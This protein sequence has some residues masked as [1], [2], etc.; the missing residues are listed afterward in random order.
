MCCWAPTVLV[1]Q[2]QNHTFVTYD[3]FHEYTVIVKRLYDSCLR[4]L[5]AHHRHHVLMLGATGHWTL[6]AATPSRV[7]ELFNWNNPNKLLYNFQLFHAS[8]V[9]ELVTQ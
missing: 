2:F 9:D 7:N 4:Q 3:N 6:N 5:R 1:C 8:F